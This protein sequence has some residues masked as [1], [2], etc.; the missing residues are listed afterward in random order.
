MKRT[1]T[2]RGTISFPMLDGETIEQAEDRLFDALD[3]VD[4]TVS[5]WEEPKIWEDEDETN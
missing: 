2:M 5:T 4:T 3:A 1:L